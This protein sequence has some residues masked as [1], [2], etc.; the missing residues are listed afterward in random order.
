MGQMGLSLAPALPR[1]IE[2]LAA[3]QAGFLPGD[4]SC[5]LL[6]E[7]WFGGRGQRFFL[8]GC[9][10]FDLCLSVG[11]VSWFTVALSA[12]P[13]LLMPSTC[14]LRAVKGFFAFL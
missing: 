7:L 13:L 10:G 1:L 3:P 14:S 6:G 5:G 4:A 8:D 12:L 11:I 9:W 2:G